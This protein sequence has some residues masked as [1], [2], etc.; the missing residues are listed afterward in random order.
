[1][2][3]L[4]NTIGQRLCDALGLPKRVRSIQINFEVNEPVTA[5]VT[6][7]PD[8]DAAEEVVEIVKRFELV[9]RKE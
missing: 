9:E 2:A 8:A 6:L 4:S 5:I 7:I 3:V 1:M